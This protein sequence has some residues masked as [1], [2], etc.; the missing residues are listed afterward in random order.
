M[1]KIRRKYGLGK[2]FYLDCWP[3]GNSFAVITDPEIANQITTATSLSKS[4]VVVEYMAKLLGSQN[5]V[6]LNG[7]A[8]KVMRKIFNP[9]FAMGHLMTLVPYIVDAA[10]VFGEILDA[11]AETGEQFEMEELATRL[12]V[13]VIGK[14]SLDT[15]LN[16][17]RSPHRIVTAFRK[18]AL[19][20]PFTSPA[21]PFVG[22]TAK[23]MSP[24]RLWLNGRKLDQYIGEALDQRQSQRSADEKLE[25]SGGKIK[26]RYAVDLA[27]DTYEKEFQVKHR[28]SDHDRGMDPVFRQNA[29][30][31][32]KTFIFAGHDTTSSTIAWIFYFL[33][34]HPSIQ[35]KVVKELDNVFGPRSSQPSV[36][37]RLRADPYLTNRLSYSNA[38]IKETLRLFPPASTIRDGDPSVTFFD[39]SDPA[40]HYPTAGFDV[41]VNSHASHRSED[42]FPQPYNFV[43]ERH[44]DST[45]IPTP[46]F[47][48]A[49]AHKD[50]WR[51]FEK[52]PRNCLGQE[53]AMLEIRVIM[54]MTMR[55]FDF[56]AVYPELAAG[57]KK[58]L[59]EIEGHRCYQVLKGSAKPKGGI[60][61][62][63]RR[64]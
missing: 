40:R 7:A 49:K 2:F 24:L 52:G 10:V 26:P 57:E 21:N 4:P 47:P 55:D 48:N 20:M 59:A 5:M 43:P 36:A 61:G 50:A 8:W 64:R 16:S 27:L 63:I 56:E 22:L 38:V 30:D 45:I 11:K 13:D 41:W 29:I 12:T 51:P 25:L 6:G 39:P 23:I 32:I 34:Q 60:P 58:H 54:A 3:F 35:A 31:Q 1:D 15:N 46:P 17:Q 28:F 14:V 9:G 18:Q 53:L 44:L 42:Y 19:L 33:H 62:V 37:D